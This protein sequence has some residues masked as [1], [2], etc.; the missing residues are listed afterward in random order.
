[1]QESH[2]FDIKMGLHRETVQK[3]KKI[4][5]RE[6]GKMADGKFYV[7]WFLPQLGWTL[8][9]FSLLDFLCTCVWLVFI[10][11]YL[12]VKDTV[13]MSDPHEGQQMPWNWN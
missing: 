11:A 12:C 2:K 6:R 8:F 4:L 10:S 1:M 5:K 13:H 3:K 9:L 7:L